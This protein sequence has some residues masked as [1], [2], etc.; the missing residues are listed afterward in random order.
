VS[1]TSDE[2]CD[3]PARARGLCEMHY[4]RLKRRGLDAAGRRK[5]RPHTTLERLAQEGRNSA[6]IDC[7]VPPMFGGMRCEGCFQ[8]RCDERAKRSQVEAL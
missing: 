2:G 8:V 5:P 3:R 1:C 4:T 7:G 6:C